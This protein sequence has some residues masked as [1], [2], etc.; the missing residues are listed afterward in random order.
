MTHLFPNYKR[1]SI[2]FVGGEKQHLFD[3]E[4]NAY[5]DLT[6]GI[7]VMNLGYHHPALNTALQTQAEQIWHTPN[8][9]ENSLQEEV[10]KLLA[11][12]EDYL[13]YFCN[14]GAEA[15]E[16]A[17]KLARKATGKK[18]IITFLQSFHGRTF[19]ALSATGQKSIHEGYYPLLPEFVYLPYN[20]IA[21]L[22]EALYEETAAVMLELIQGEGGIIPAE[23]EWIAEVSQLCRE[24]GIL[25]IIDEVQT[26][27]G[28]TG[29]LYAF[30][31]WGIQPDIF[32]LAKGLGNGFPVGAMVGK[33]TLA[34]AFG[35]GSHGSTFGGNKLGMSVA[36]EVL[37]W[38][39]SPEFLSEVTEKGKKAIEYLS[40]RL[41]DT[42]NVRAVRGKGLM[43]GIELASPE[44]LEKAIANLLDEKIVV[45]KAGN[46]V[47]R[48]L[49]PLTITQEELAFGIEKICQVL[50]E[51]ENE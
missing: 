9:Y 32:T 8:L 6:S 4:G 29:S 1:Q 48:L 45:L 7:G 46:N 41:I 26:G 31:Q 18:K 43:I 3:K 12:G 35:P 37:Q 51:L 15:N 5:L 16:A 11:D 19:G 23:K 14:S 49:P 22:K 38:T 21:D 2:E 30:Q 20:S 24:K 47:L 28:R 17:I 25:L 33:S 36:K 50:E 42:E 27:I 34:S 39:R 10:G 40:S 13:S 44:C